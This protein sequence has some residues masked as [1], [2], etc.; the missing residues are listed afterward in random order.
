[1]S[2]K[3]VA[4]KLN[5]SLDDGLRDGDVKERQQRDGPNE[6][7]GGGGVSVWSILAGQVF[8]E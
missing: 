6:L 5:T 4:H 3:E 1:M 7:T 2:S 8:S